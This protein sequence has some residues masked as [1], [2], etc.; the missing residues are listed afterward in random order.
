MEDKSSDI[1]IFLEKNCPVGNFFHT[2]QQ[3]IMVTKI[4]LANGWVE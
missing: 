1:N 2:V 3:M 4:S